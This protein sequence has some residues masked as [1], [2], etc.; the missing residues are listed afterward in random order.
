MRYI[1][2]FALLGFVWAITGL[3]VMSLHIGACAPALRDI[4]RDGV[5][6]ARDNCPGVA[7][8][9]QED[10]DGDGL[11]D[12]CDACPHD[13]A[14]DLDE[15][16]VCDDVDNCPLVPNGDQVDRDHD[17]AGDHCDCDLLPAD[18]LC[19]DLQSETLLARCVAGT[20]VGYFDIDRD[21]LQD[22][23]DCI[24]GTADNIRTSTL[25]LPRL[26]V[27]GEANIQRPLSG[28]HRIAIADGD[29]TIAEFDWNCRYP[30]PLGGFIL[31]SAMIDG[32]GF[33]LLSGLPLSFGRTNDLLV[34]LAAAAFADALPLL[35]VT[36]SPVSPGKVGRFLRAAYH[37]ML[38]FRRAPSSLRRAHSGRVRFTT[39]H[40]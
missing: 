23:H 16:A 8:P 20:C 39:M 4:D 9:N 24:L 1:R 13:E 28:V 19:N 14:N 35:C 30:L 5:S 31:E 10:A 22:T 34:P 7:N 26:L 18:A 2:P 21:G 25:R 6:R 29:R 17:G 32:G 12:A 3:G 11:G 38:W 36:E 33:V 37:H 40:C 27:D 15:D